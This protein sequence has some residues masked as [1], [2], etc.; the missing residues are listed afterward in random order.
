M[1]VLKDNEQYLLKHPF[2]CYIAGPSYSGKTT[3]IQKILLNQQNLI[4]KPIDKIVF[5]YKAMQPAYDIFK[6]LPNE[7]EFFEGL[8][9]VDIFNPEKNNLLVIDDLMEQCKDNKDILNLFMV[10]SHHKNISV[11]LVSQNIYIKGKC[12]RDINLNSSNMI[13]FKNPR[14]SVQI[15]VLARQ[16]FPTNSKAF[17]EAFYDAVKDHRYIFLDFNHETS[18]NLRIQTN[19]T[20]ENRIIYTF[21]N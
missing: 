12:T 4:D 10:D 1:W 16:M 2:R 6:Y 7:V 14:D 3:L 11:F 8:I 18:D 20:E 17:L 21:L 19:I 15:S 9:N 13:I 5:C